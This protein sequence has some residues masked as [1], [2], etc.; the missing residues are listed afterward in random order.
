MNDSEIDKLIEQG[1]SGPG[2]SEMFRAQVL[3]DS[4]AALARGHGH[5]SHWRTAGLAAAAVL[6]A[7]VSFFWGRAS[8][9]VAP[10]DPGP[11]AGGGIETAQTVAVPADLVAWLKAARLF[12]Q[13]GM[14]KRVTLAY[15]HA[16]ALVPARMYGLGDRPQTT[17]AAQGDR[18]PA[19]PSL[20]P[21]RD[22]QS[23][24]AQS[25]GE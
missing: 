20:P 2:A 10:A 17:L 16:S 11:V 3:R 12:E 24:L 25:F 21:S 15:E 1:L 8:A 5:G 4:T 23:I 13:L 18:I 19:Q 14:D 6:I 9:P 22:I 7:A